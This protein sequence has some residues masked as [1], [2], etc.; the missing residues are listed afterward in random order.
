MLE[1]PETLQLF[2][3]RSTAWASAALAN[4]RLG[5]AEPCLALGLRLE[6]LQ[7]IYTVS[8]LDVR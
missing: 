6:K 3:W 1:C 7:V 4:N 5:A 2:A 8:L